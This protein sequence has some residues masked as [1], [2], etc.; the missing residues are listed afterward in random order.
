MYVCVSLTPIPSHTQNIQ[1]TH[2]NSKGSKSTKLHRSNNL[3]SSVCLNHRT[4]SCIVGCS[5]VNIVLP[6]RNLVNQSAISSNRMTHTQAHK[7]PKLYN[8]TIKIQHLAINGQKE[9]EREAER[10][11][12]WERINRTRDKFTVVIYTLIIINSGSCLCG[13]CVFA[14]E[15]LA[16]IKILFRPI[17][18]IW[19]GCGS[20]SDI[21]IEWRFPYTKYERK[22]V[23]WQIAIYV[24][25]I[26]FQNWTCLKIS[27]EC[28]QARAYA[29][30]DGKHQITRKNQESHPIDG[31]PHFYANT[32]TE[33]R[34]NQL[35]TE[36][37][38]LYISALVFALV[39]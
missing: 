9:T 15:C 39:E 34:V 35:A 30:F 25:Q 28:E 18:C 12:E 29:P 27:H 32:K 23:L 24:K 33:T 20:R 13:V 2:I 37:R 14:R 5:L 21:Y 19:C 17:S 26:R 11:G 8:K 38:C 6:I 4:S 36:Y 10:E 31:L 7:Q 16:L 22:K 3:I 1:A